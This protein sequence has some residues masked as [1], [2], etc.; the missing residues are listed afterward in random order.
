MAGQRSRRLLMVRLVGMAAASLPSEVADR[1][2]HALD[3]LVQVRRTQPAVLAGL[4]AHPETGMLLA[5][6]LTEARTGTQGA[7]SAAGDLTALAVVAAQRAG[8]ELTAEL[9]ARDG[10]VRLPTAGSVRAPTGG[11]VGDVVVVRTGP[12]MSV[13][14]VRVPAPDDVDQPSELE[15]RRPHR[16]AATSARS[17]I[18]VELDD[19]SPYRRIY[20]PQAAD[21]LDD[22][23]AASWQSVL[24]RA[25]PLIDRC[26]PS[27]AS[28]MARGWLRVVVPLRPG[29]QAV[30]DSVREAVGS[31][32]ATPPTDERYLAET[33]IH[34]V[35][36]SLLWALS[37]LVPLWSADHTVRYPSPWRADQRPTFGLLH[38][39]FA[40]LAVAEFWA[41]LSG[42]AGDHGAASIAQAR[43]AEVRQALQTLGGAHTLTEAGNRLVDRLRTRL[44]AALPSTT[45][46][47]R[48]HEASEPTRRSECESRTP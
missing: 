23:A 9:V 39:A 46:K 40:F 18:K 11:D 10:W 28:A 16:L 6:A 5:T 15:W 2:E 27:G 21:R 45:A 25:W 38:G 37:A 32:S 14:G 43:R 19:D 34:E 1:V 41:A 24:E 33:V 3:V 20:G 8:M 31:L 47:A 7:S 42:C 26:A 22:A 13:G 12:V 48:K 29:S 44:D 35:Q 17:A 36:H 4:L 30:S